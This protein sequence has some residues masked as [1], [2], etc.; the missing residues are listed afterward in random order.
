MRLGLGGLVAFGVAG[1]LAACGAANPSSSDAG[2][3]DAGTPEAGFG[4]DAGPNPRA[5]WPSVVLI[6]GATADSAPSSAGGTLNLADMRVCIYDSVKNQPLYPYALPDKSPMPLAS[7]PGVRRGGGIDLGGFGFKGDVDV[8]V[9][10]AN[11][12][13]GDAAWEPD[14]QRTGYDCNTI[15]CE[16]D[17]KPCYPHVKLH[18]SISGDVAALGVVDGTT[19]LQALAVQLEE[20]P[21]SGAPG[22][23]HG[24]F[25]AL[26]A[27]HAGESLSALYDTGPA[28]GPLPTGAQLVTDQIASYE[29]DDVSFVAPTDQFTQSLDSIAFVSDP[30]LAPPDFYGVRE[31]FV[32]ALVGDPA[33]TQSVQQNG[34]RDPAFDG[35]GL[36]VAAIPYGTPTAQ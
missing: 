14:A 11:D 36:H 33:A 16:N 26:S 30:T 15:T 10:S 22:S 1:A 34:G 20:T 12:L 13:S 2:R 27:W 5:F 6:H 17:Q 28:I 3:D 21:Y 31:N 8:Y 18:A 25:V 35:K 19:G 9:F 23:L 4:A 32:F 7:Y 29:T 24:A